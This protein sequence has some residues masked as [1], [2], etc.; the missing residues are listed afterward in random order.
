MQIEINK[1]TARLESAEFFQIVAAKVTDSDT[2]TERNVSHRP[3]ATR[4][5]LNETDVVE[6]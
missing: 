4:P 2:D 6:G 3:K 1:L 5:K